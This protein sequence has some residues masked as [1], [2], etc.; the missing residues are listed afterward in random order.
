[1]MNESQFSNYTPRL[2]LAQK[3]QLQQQSLNR[4]R[5][6]AEGNVNQS[7]FM[8]NKSNSNPSNLY[9]HHHQIAPPSS[10]VFRVTLPFLRSTLTTTATNN[11]ECATF[12]AHVADLTQTGDDLLWHIIAQSRIRF[13]DLMEVGGFEWTPG[14]ASSLVLF[15]LSTEEATNWVETD[16]SKGGAARAGGA[17]LHYNA[18]TPIHRYIPIARA[19]KKREDGRAR[20]GN[21]SAL[22]S[23]ITEAMTRNFQQVGPVVDVEIFVLLKSLVPTYELSNENLRKGLV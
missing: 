4:S 12:L 17:F 20:A 10:L 18:A 1:M 14:A 6:A 22:S 16:Q 3:L 19:L 11:S 21:M 23:T 7:G 2:T 15:A 8:F 5:G 9:H 13:P